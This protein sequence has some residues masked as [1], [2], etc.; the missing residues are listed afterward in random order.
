MK[1]VGRFRSIILVLTRL[2]IGL[3]DPRWPGLHNEILF[4]IKQNRIQVGT[5]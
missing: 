3:R 5:A 2:R 1:K 4:Q